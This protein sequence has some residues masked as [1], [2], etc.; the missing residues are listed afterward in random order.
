[1][2]KILA[3]LLS[4]ELSDYLKALALAIITPLLIALQ[5]SLDSGQWHIDWKHAAMEALGA[6]IAYILKNWIQA[7]PKQ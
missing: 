1:M 4:L 6:G 5:Q 3:K 2:K 7:Q